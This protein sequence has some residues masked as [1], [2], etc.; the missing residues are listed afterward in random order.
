MKEGKRENRKV[1]EGGM[2]KITKITTNSSTPPADMTPS[3]P[4]MN[5]NAKQ[6]NNTKKMG[7]KINGYYKIVFIKVLITRGL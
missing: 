1:R 5:I 4:A 3:P 2:K 6:T 7:K